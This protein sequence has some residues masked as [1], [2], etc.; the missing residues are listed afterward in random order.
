MSIISAALK[1]DF[2]SVI[3]FINFLR[4]SNERESAVSLSVFREAC[5]KF[6]FF[7]AKDG[8]DYAVIE[9][10]DNEVYAVVL[11]NSMF[12]SIDLNMGD[13]VVFQRFDNRKDAIGCVFDVVLTDNDLID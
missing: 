3:Q 8:N 2:V 7:K 9:V 5:E 10:Q 1:R 4:F 13:I 12:D 11:T 6:A